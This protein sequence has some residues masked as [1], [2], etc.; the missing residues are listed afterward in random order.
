M[1]LNFIL[2]NKCLLASHYLVATF[3]DVFAFLFSAMLI[4]NTTHEPLPLLEIVPGQSVLLLSSK[5]RSGDPS[6]ISC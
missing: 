6:Q 4:V 2:Y 5:Q 3:V 1:V